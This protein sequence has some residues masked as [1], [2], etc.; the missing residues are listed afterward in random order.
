[1]GLK[2]FLNEARIPEKRK[3]VALYCRVSTIEQAEEGY[4]IDEQER[5][6]EE[7][8]K[9]N[10]YSI[11]KCYSDRGISGKDIK[12][13]PQ[14]KEL[15]SD[16]QEK[17][18]DMVISWKINRISRKLSD[19]LKIV[20]I[21]EENN[22]IFKSYSE[23]FETNTPA[24]KMQFQMMALISEFERGTISQNVRMGLCA[25]ARAGEWCGGRVLG[26]DLVPM[27]NQE[28]AKR[29]KTKLT[30]NENEAEIVKLIF[31]E[32]SEGKG[33]KAITSKLN[34]LGYKTK[35]GNNFSV[36]SIKDIL[37]NPVYIGKVRYN[38][39]QNWS[40]KRRR[41]I[42]P[43]PIITDGIHEAIIDEKLWDKVQA[44]LESKQGKPARIYDGEYPLTGI[45]K[46][47]K[48]GAGMVIMRTTNTL[49][50]GTKR[51]IQYYAC[52]NWKNKGTSV[53][54]SNSI[55]VDKANEYVFNKLS[56]L[57][58]NEKMV[59]TIVNNINK[60]RH[61]KINPAKKDL[62]RIDK[63]LEKIDKKKTKLFEGYEEDLISKEEFKERKDELN[64]RAKSLQEEK[65]PLLVT[66]SDDV[67]EE[68]PYEFIKS[69]LENFGKVLTESATREQQKKLL[70]MII[71]EIT[72]NEAR[73]IDSI[74]LKINDSL[75]DY[76][77]KEEG[78]SIKDAPS[79]F[80]LR[81]I[82]VNTLNLDIAI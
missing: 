58:S 52:G 42:N 60:E 55:R 78:V 41:N 61:K 33:Y 18:F 15:L 65:E 25:K 36:A 1:M 5:L 17:K 16:A 19:V 46:C 26:Y 12:N 37:T 47:P 4:S 45:L 66:L 49:K 57:L 71:S 68:I 34:R 11:Y 74:K 9:K 38:V 30:I 67:S 63:E 73:E 69:I 56:E 80:L 64:K 27:E 77:S 2:K 35:R 81:N 70:H 8:C 76:I 7:W 50:D 48:C 51:R 31:N 28:G 3:L 23:P 22:V 40:E 6:L 29:R 82:G 44:I 13:R 53:C 39:R 24:G 54:N 20:D 32:Y 75:V 72:I 21:L 62:E 59:E 43:N 14:L 79:S 10:N